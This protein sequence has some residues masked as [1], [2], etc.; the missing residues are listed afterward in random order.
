MNIFIIL[1]IFVILASLYH[2]SRESFFTGNYPQLYN[3]KE[4]PCRSG[5]QNKNYNNAYPS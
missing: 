2:S 1:C 3:S 4:M 5:A